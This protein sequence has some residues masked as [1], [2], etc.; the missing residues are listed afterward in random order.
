M[1]DATA[2]I[3]FVDSLGEGFD[4]QDDEAENDD[5]DFEI[6]RGRSF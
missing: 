3:A 1:I 2:K 4:H 5:G 6:G